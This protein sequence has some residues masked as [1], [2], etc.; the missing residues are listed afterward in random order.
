M[1]ILKEIAKEGG[2]AKMKAG[3]FTLYFLTGETKS[4]AATW[5]H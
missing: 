1:I 3:N 5:K 4:P 2:G